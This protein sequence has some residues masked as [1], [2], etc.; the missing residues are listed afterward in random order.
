[1]VDI[2][3][4]NNCSCVHP[5]PAAVLKDILAEGGKTKRNEH[6]T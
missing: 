1:M 6:S 3:E 4:L 5:L 2:V